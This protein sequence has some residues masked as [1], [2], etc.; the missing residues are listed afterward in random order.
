MICIYKFELMEII[1]GSGLYI[2]KE[3]GRDLCKKNTKNLI[4]KNY[5]Y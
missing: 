1:G 5:N 2:N 3:F 4:L